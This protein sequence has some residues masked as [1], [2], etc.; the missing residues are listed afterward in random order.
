[1][2]VATKTL[3]RTTERAHAEKIAQRGYQPCWL[4]RI[5][6]ELVAIRGAEDT[7]EPRRKQKD[8]GGK[9]MRILKWN[10]ICALAVLAFMS[11]AD[12]Q[13]APD[14]IEGHLAAGKNAAGGPR[15]HP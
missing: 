14:S 11:A 9:I 12:A 15:R 10:I 6:L 13:T 8:S 4:S 5:S 3:E 1:L 2:T 7:Q